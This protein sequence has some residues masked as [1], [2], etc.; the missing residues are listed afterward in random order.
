MTVRTLSSSRNTDFLK[1]RKGDFEKPA[2]ATQSVDP[3][4]V[5]SDEN[6]THIFSFLVMP[7]PAAPRISAPEQRKPSA[8]KCDRPTNVDK[9]ITRITGQLP[10]VYDV[11]RLYA[12]LARVCRGWKT[13]VEQSLLPMLLNANLDGLP[14]ENCMF[15]CILWMC[16]HRIN[17]LH[18][19]G[20]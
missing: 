17:L 6:W 12:C 14:S 10:W 1:W 9:E 13:G 8:Y 11:A 5:L 20:P 18:S 16:K 2:A 15:D 4:K 3:M 7:K 19:C